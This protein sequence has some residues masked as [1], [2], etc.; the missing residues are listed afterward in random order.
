MPIRENNDESTRLEQTRRVLLTLFFI[1]FPFSVFYQQVTLGAL[2]GV[3]GWQCWERKALPTTLLDRPLLLF[4][5]VMLLASLFS[6][7]VLNSLAGY[8]K[9]WLV[10]AFFVSATL[11]HDHKEAERLITLLVIA[12]SV[13]AAYGIVQHYIGIDL[14]KQLRGMP[15]ALDPYWFGRA[16]GWRTKGFHPS[17]ITFAHNLL[18]PLTFATVWLSRAG[19]AVR[20][21]LWLSLGWGLMVFAL[22]FSLTRGVWLAYLVVLA[23]LGI[24]RGGRTLVGVTGGA[25]LLVIF[26]MSAGAGVQ[27]RLWSTFNFV[28]NLPR[29]QIWQANIDMI[30]ERPVLGWGYGNYRKFRDPFYAQHPEANHTGHAHNTFLQVA[31][32]SGLLGLTAFLFFF[33]SLL[34]MGWETYQRIPPETEPL[35]CFVLGAVLSIVGFLI[36]GVTQHNFG[37]AEVVVV[38]WAVSGVIVSARLWSEE[39]D[40]SREIK[41]QMAK[42]KNQK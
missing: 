28:Q 2:L 19:M 33:W 10:G 4:F 13:V 16:E 5:A 42:G 34:R 40:V 22:L 27:E 32:D 14:N 6:P 38:M 8:R 17:G 1:S 29:S 24:I 35:R 39:N 21:R 7:E 31:V 12:A 30:K 25:G 37:D 9:L 18:F 36:G 15:P 11:I 26:L 20:Q 23:L 3:L 41:R